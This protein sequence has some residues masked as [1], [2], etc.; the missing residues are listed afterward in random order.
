MIVLTAP[1]IMMIGQASA[2]AAPVNLP[3]FLYVNAS[4][5]PVGVGQTVYI[6]LFVTKP[7]PTLTGG[8]SLG[9]DYLNMKI[10]IVKPDGTNITLGPYESDATGGVPAVTF[11]PTVEGNYTFQGIYPGQVLGTNPNNGLV[12]NLDPAVSPAVTVAVQANPVSYWYSSPLPTAYWTTPIYASNYGWAQAVGGNWYGLGRPGF[13]NTGGYDG[14]GNNFQPYS[15]APTTAHVLWTL[16]ITTGGQPGGETAANEITAFAANSPLYHTF[17]PIILNGVLYYGWYPAQTDYAGI[18]AV[19]LFTGQTMWVKNTTDTLIYG[20]VVTFH[21]VEEFG[22]QA[23]LWAARVTSVS[24]SGL[25]ASATYN[26][27][28][29]DPVTGNYDGISVQHTI[30]HRQPLR[31]FTKRSNRLQRT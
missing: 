17:E 12:Y 11:V 8:Y 31:D 28:I 30:K 7:V 29:L 9:Q 3:T 16:P 21:T 19:N 23:F 13:D 24:G 1:M 22:S 4:P 18:V 15:T 27:D 14:S 26:Y 25:F 2:A 5:T 6:T 10:N 20:Q